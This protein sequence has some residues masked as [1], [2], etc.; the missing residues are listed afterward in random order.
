M[1]KKCGAIIKWQRMKKTGKHMPIDPDPVFIVQG[2]GKLTFITDNGE[3]VTGRTAKE[4]E[5]TRET[6]TAFVPHWATCPYAD[7]FRKR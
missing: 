6:E 3:T 2:D 4:Q 7:S 1:C 5:I